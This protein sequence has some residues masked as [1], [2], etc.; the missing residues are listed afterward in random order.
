M[1]RQ[2]F[3]V[4]NKTKA[5][6]LYE[7]MIM[8][9]AASRVSPAFRTKHPE[10][11]WKRLISLRN[12][13]IHVYDAVNFDIVWTTLTKYLPRIEADVAGLLSSKEDAEEDEHAPPDIV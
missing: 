1:S 7:L 4:D 5:A 11:P 6:T 10:I 8:G 3:L 2:A 9:E 12:F 13:Y